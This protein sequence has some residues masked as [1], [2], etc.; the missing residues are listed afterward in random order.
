MLASSRTIPE[1]DPLKGDQTSLE[2]VGVEGVAGENLESNLPSYVDNSSLEEFQNFQSGSIFST[3]VLA[4]LAAAITAVFSDFHIASSLLVG[5]FSG[6]LYLWLL[7]RSVQKLG[8]DSQ[9]LAKTQLLV[10]VVLF[11]ASTKLPFLELFPAIVGFFLYKPAVLLKV[12][13]SD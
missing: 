12:F 9:N 5:G 1:P 6:A 8:K 3:L 2:T 10:P 4:A 7:A 13:L 11:L